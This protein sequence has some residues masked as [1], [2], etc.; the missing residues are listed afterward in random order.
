MY[1]RA[2]FV[3][4]IRVNCDDCL[5]ALC[6]FVVGASNTQRASF[7][8]CRV[9]LLLCSLLLSFVYLQNR[10]ARFPR[11]GAV[12]E[13]YAVYETHITGKVHVYVLSLIHI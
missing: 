1:W 13:T 4:V 11:T 8:W 2:W 3:V 9:M 5:P 7:F 6:Y 12:Y 10:S